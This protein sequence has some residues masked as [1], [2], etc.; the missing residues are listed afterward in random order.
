MVNVSD[1]SLDDLMAVADS[2]SLTR[3]DKAINQ[4]YAAVERWPEFAKA[5]GVNEKTIQ[6]IS[7][8]HRLDLV[9]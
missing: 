8:N 1:F 9:K 6:E 5:A 7:A 4:V 3:T 2:I